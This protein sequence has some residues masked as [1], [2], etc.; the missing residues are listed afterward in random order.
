M[1]DKR[2]LKERF[3]E[4][5]NKTDSCW[6]WTG[7]ITNYG[8]GQL[9]A[10]K[11]LKKIF[12]HRASLILIGTDI[13]KWMHV[14]HICRVRRCVNPDHLRV[15]T[16]SINAMENNIGGIG[17]VNSNKKYCNNGHEYSLSNTLYVRR[18]S[19][20]KFRRCGLCQK[21]WNKSYQNNLKHKQVEI[22]E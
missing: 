20:K 10:T 18:P 21:N 16:P 6:L 15:V 7:Y 11:N 2:T 1:E 12:A 17:V 4:R 19:G 5:V 22:N 13:P 14:D 9:G 3:E 8:Y